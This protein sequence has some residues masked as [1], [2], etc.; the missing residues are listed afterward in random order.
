MKKINTFTFLLLLAGFASC[1]GADIPLS[2][3]DK[4][5]LQGEPVMEK[6]T[7]YE[8]FESRGLKVDLRMAIYAVRLLKA[9]GTSIVA[10]AAGQKVEA[11]CDPKTLR[12]ITLAGKK[13]VWLGL[14]HNVGTSKLYFRIIDP[15]TPGVELSR[16]DSSDLKHRGSK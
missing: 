5:S 13:T 4:L 10:D 2:D 6:E 7:A 8:I 1:A 14:V 11:L 12:V 3:D 9:A 15:T 16:F